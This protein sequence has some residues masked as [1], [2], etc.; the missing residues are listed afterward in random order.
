MNKYLSMKM[1]LLGTLVAC[2]V[3]AMGDGIEQN[4][5][6]QN[7]GGAT[8]PAPS[9]YDLLNDQRDQPIGPKNWLGN[10]KWYAQEVDKKLSL[11]FRTNPKDQAA[12]EF[13]A[14]DQIQSDPDS[15]ATFPSA[16]RTFF[17]LSLPEGETIEKCAYRPDSIE[18]RTSRA[19]YSVMMPLQSFGS[20]VE[21]QSRGADTE[22]GL[23]IESGRLLGSRLVTPAPLVVQASPG[24]MVWTDGPYTVVFRHNGE[25]KEGKKETWELR[26]GDDG[27]LRLAVAFHIDPKIAQAE[28]DRLFDK[29]AEAR[30]ESRREWNEYLASCPVTDFPEGYRYV[31]KTTGKTVEISRQQLMER[32]LWHWVCGLVNAY[33]IDFNNMPALDDPGQKHLVRMLGE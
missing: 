21:W 8:A 30:A 33:D 25:L 3:T 12:A 11:V 15:G 5:R 23:K 17:R 29:P 20:L 10:L 32:Q 1:T 22:S 9:G 6:E 31:E 13:V 18:A 7:A 16:R 24:R 28:A 26:P 19:D 2:S 4:K 14:A 27:K